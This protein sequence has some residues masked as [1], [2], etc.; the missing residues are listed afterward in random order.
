MI[1]ERV[2]IDDLLGYT[3]YAF[4]SG[5]PRVLVL[6]GFTYVDGPA[7]A[8]LYLAIRKLKNADIRGYLAI[9]PTV[10]E[11]AM[12]GYL[13]RYVDEVRMWSLG[14]IVR[15]LLSR[16]G[17]DVIAIAVTCLDRCIDFSSCSDEGLGEVLPTEIVAIGYLTPHLKQVLQ[18][19]NRWIALYLDCSDPLSP[20]KVVDSVLHILVSLGI[21]KKRSSKAKRRVVDVYECY[22]EWSGIVV[23][24]KRVGEEVVESSIIALVDEHEVKACA[25]GFV[26]H[27]RRSG[28][29][30]KGDLVAII[31]SY[32]T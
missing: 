19:F 28:F 3:L 20:N 2:W 4:G 26:L 14:E 17:R 29:V 11:T 27:I 30:R 24:A 23:P 6:G 8:G 16:F 5:D 25:Q 21:V 9:V 32:R 10:L 13:P 1:V 15:S 18:V 22:S 7:S 31:A 12:R